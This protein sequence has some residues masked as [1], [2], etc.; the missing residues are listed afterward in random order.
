MSYVINRRIFKSWLPNCPT[1]CQDCKTALLHG[2][3][4][5]KVS[6]VRLQARNANKTVF[7]CDATMLTPPYPPPKSKPTRYP[8]TPFARSGCG[9]GGAVL[10]HRGDGRVDTVRMTQAPFTE[11]SIE[12]SSGIHPAPAAVA[13]AC[14]CQTWSAVRCATQTVDALRLPGTRLREDVRSTETVLPAGRRPPWQVTAQVAFYCIKH[15][16]RLTTYR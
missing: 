1:S 8:T 5:S 2:E 3:E 14:G 16:L 12:K 7:S 9:Q 13:G 6:A 15:N 10:R 4:G 11:V